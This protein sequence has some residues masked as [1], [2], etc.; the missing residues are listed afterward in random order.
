M[1]MYIVQEKCANLEP[2][3]MSGICSSGTCMADCLF[4]LML[5][6]KFAVPKLVLI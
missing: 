1:Q 6:G 5:V 3:W 2:R 4:S